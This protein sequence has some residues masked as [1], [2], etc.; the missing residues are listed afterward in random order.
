MRRTRVDLAGLAQYWID[1]VEALLRACVRD[2]DQVAA[3]QSIDV[4]FDELMA[5]DID[6]VTQIY[7]RA[8]LE[9]TRAARSRSSSEP[10]A[11]SGAQVDGPRTA[12][13]MPASR[14]RW[15]S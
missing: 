14:R 5:D 7:A 12:A 3:L 10:G 2:R 15:M 8:G 1:R 6:M 4:R 13:S 9:M 11:S